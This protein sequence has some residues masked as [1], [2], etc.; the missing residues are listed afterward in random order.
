MVGH[1]VKGQHGSLKCGVLYSPIVPAIRISMLTSWTG[2]VL[3]LYM[4][5]NHTPRKICLQLKPLVTNIQNM[6]IT[7][8]VILG[9]EVGAK[10]GCQ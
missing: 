5:I 8:H 2:L 1:R 7:P 6:Q 9:L 3:A 4:A 10:E